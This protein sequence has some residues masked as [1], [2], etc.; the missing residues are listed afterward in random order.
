M[1]VYI[2]H[3]KKQLEI[4]SASSWTGLDRASGTLRKSQAVWSVHHIQNHTFRVTLLQPARRAAVLGQHSS[5]RPYWWR[6][7]AKAGQKETESTIII[8]RLCTCISWWKL[9][10]G[11]SE[12]TCK[13]YSAMCAV[14]KVVASVC[15]P[16]QLECTQACHT[17]K[18][19]IQ[20]RHVQNS[21]SIVFDVQ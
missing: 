12:C 15:T 3:L 14:V 17:L 16:V 13:H 21:N 6:P 1:V 9:G 11:M 2:Y 19:G 4:P 10:R 18:W 5:L 7:R 20:R 8:I